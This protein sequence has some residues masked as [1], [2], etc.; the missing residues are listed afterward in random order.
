MQSGKNQVTGFGDGYG[1][2]YSLKVAHLAQKHDVGILAQAAAQGGRE[3]IS[4]VMDFT[5]DYDGLNTFMSIFDR[6]FDSYYVGR[7]FN[8]NLMD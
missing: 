1:G 8:V 7:F 5:L 4:I 3:R 2:G 6:V